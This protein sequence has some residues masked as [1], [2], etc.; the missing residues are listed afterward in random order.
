MDLRQTFGQLKGHTLETLGRAKPFTVVVVN[1]R[2]IVVRPHSTN[3]D[4]PIRRIEIESALGELQQCGELSLVNIRK[5]HHSEVNPAYVAALLATL[6]GVS[7]ITNP[8]R[9]RL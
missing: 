6:P 7:K 9:L 3:Q 2:S 8:I 5:N 1:E 4:R